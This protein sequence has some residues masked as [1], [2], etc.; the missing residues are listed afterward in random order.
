MIDEKGRST[1]QESTEIEIIESSSALEAI[2]RA[3]IDVQIATAHKYRMHTSA[4][5]IQRF[6]NDAIAFATM[7]REIAE[8]CLYT[9]PSRGQGPIE[10]RSVRLAEILASA[11]GNI[12]VSSRITEMGENFV[13]VEGIAHDLEKNYAAKTETK[14]RITTKT[15]KRYS[16]DM[17]IMTCNA[18]ASIAIRN[19]IFKV[20]PAALVD[21]VYRAARASAVGDAKSI[22]IRRSKAIQ[23]FAL[24]GVDEKRVLGFL[25]VLSVADISSDHIGILLGAYNSIRDG[26]VKIEELFPIEEAPV[27][28][29]SALKDKLKSRGKANAHDEPT[30]PPA[31]EH[32][33]DSD[34]SEMFVG[35]DDGNR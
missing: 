26:E 5:D 1:M 30:V 17:I 34:Q 33:F 24:L 3:E 2:S 18:A 7:D 12:R 21:P 4:I 8:S 10:G 28:T 25:R 11:W 32:D 9:L 16:D 13:T 19:A 23:K 29:T 27:S 20:I 35:D 6:Q 15:G 31:P 22:E 14:R